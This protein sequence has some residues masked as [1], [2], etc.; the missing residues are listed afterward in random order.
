MAVPNGSKFLF[1]VVPVFAIAIIGI[2]LLFSNSSEKI[3]NLNVAGDMD[4]I[5]FETLRI[6]VLQEGDGREAES[7]DEISVNYRGT[8]KDGTEFD[9]SY[10]RNEPFTFVLGIG[11]VIQG[12]DEGVEG[13]KVGEKRRLEIPSSMGYGEFGTGPIPGNA[14]L[15][16]EVELIS[17]N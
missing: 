6:D 11:Q 17:I 15:V 2:L 9:S 16:F 12:W 8:L 1:F 3:D 13:M 4:N 5:D 7:G 14:G 10:S